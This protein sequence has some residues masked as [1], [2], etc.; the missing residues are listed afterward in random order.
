M[1]VEAN[2]ATFLLR[3][4]TR[5]QTARH[6]VRRVAEHVRYAEF[7]N[8]APALVVPLSMPKHRSPR[9]L[10]ART[11]TGASTWTESCGSTAGVGGG[12]A[13]T[14]GHEL[15]FVTR[16]F[17]LPDHRRR[18]FICSARALEKIICSYLKWDWL[19]RED[20]VVLLVIEC[21]TREVVFDN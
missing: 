17:A 9:R 6:P 13:L 14:R 12:L 19:P 5:D 21:A 20:Q 10:R 18:K 11:N 15:S 8:S 16:S 1:F 3:E 4:E 2:E 7:C